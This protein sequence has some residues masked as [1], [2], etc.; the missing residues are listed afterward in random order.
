MK[1]HLY[2]ERLAMVLLLLLLLALAPARA[3]NVVYQRDTTSLA[4]TEVPGDSYE[5]VFYSDSTVNFAEVPGSSTPSYA[6]F[7]GGNIG[8]TVNV[9]WKEPGVYFFKVTAMNPSGCTSNLKIGI[10]KV[11]HALPTA[12][13]TPPDTAGVCI[14]ETVKLEVTL[15]GTE[16]WSFIYTDGTSEWTVTNIQLSP[17]ILTV[18]PAPATTTQYWIKEVTDKYGTNKKPSDKIT[19]KINPLPDPSSIIHR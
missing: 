9:L 1:R 12:I 15:T 6:E 2:I 10:I 13:I 18:D 3:Q 17:Y 5:W 14:G 11:L 19:Q 7:V 16:P 8:S 4:V